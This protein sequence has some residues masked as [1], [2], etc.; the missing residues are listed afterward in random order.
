[1]IT[2]NAICLHLISV[3]REYALEQPFNCEEFCCIFL[4]LNKFFWKMKNIINYGC[5]HKKKM[6]SFNIA[7]STYFLRQQKYD[8]YRWRINILVDVALSWFC[9]NKPAMAVCLM[10]FFV[11]SCKLWKKIIN[12]WTKIFLCMFLLKM[13]SFMAFKYFRKLENIL[14]MICRIRFMFKLYVTFI[15]LN[16]ETNWLL[17]SDVW[18]PRNTQ[19]SC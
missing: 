11:N 14:L 10:W 6:R 16:C 19:R 4:F 9:I 13:F 17:T 12:C 18:V 15:S 2:H 8:E 3:Q 1:M 5:Q 7:L